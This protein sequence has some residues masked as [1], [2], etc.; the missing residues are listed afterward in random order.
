MSAKLLKSLAVG[1]CEVENITSGEVIIYWKD[2]E[3]KLQNITIP[4]HSKLN[5]ISYATV[6]QLRTSPNLKKLAGRQL[7]IL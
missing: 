4:S 3:G 7:R 2:D 5:L 1:K 6:K